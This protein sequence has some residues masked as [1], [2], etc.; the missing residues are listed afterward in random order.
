M[1]NVQAVYSVGNSLERYL[2]HV[3][4]TT[5][6]PGLPKTTTIKLFSSGEMI[7]KDAPADP[8]LSLYLYRITQNEHLR[9]SGNGDPLRYRVPLSVNLHYLMTAWSKSA[10]S[11]QLLMAWA[12]RELYMHPVLDKSALTNEGEWGAEDIVQIIPAE[13]SNED[14]MRTWDSLGVGYRLSVSYIARVVRIDPEEKTIPDAVPVVASRFGYGRREDE[15]D[16]F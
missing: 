4:R 12:M 5:P 2:N 3:L 13:L 6:P 1:A 10:E 14:I 9:T 11:E 7:E 15:P 16:E 8:T